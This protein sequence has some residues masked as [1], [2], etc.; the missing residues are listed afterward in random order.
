MTQRMATCINSRKCLLGSEFPLVTCLGFLNTKLVPSFA[1]SLFYPIQRCQLPAKGS[2]V[3]DLWPS[4][5]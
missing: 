3:L 2:S 4:R 1:F 5:C